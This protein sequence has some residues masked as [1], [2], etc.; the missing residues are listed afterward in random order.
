MTIANTEPGKPYQFPARDIVD[1]GFLELVRYG[2]RKAGTPLMEDSLRVVDAVLK[3]EAPAGPCWRRYN[4]DGYGQQPDGGPFTD[5]G[6]GRAWPLL[7]GER[8]HYELAA[9]RDARPL[10]QGDG[11]LRLA[12]R[13]APGADL[14]R[15]RHPR[16]GAVLRASHRLRDAPDV[17]PCRVHQAAS[18]RPRRHR[19][20]P[21]R[22]G[23]RSLSVGQQAAR[24]WRSGSSAVSRAA[25]PR[26][27]RC[28][29]RTRL[30]SVS[31]GPWT[32]GASR[33]TR[34]R[35]TTALGI[36]YADIVV[37]QGQQAAVRF[38]FFWPEAERWEGRDFQVEVAPKRSIA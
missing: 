12:R 38:T 11:R 4:N 27:R 18:V 6:Q 25:C 30:P 19:V 16:Q 8:G 23:R 36:H 20:R 10:H 35:S 37:P 17:G 31:V 9:G 2:I 14:G 32:T 7:T 1:A 5:W 21:H 28:A 34:R 24:T 13:N 26:E 15:G 29:S 33:Q 3:V 22:R